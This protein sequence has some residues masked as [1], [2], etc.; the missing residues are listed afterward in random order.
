MVFLSSE[1]VCACFDYSYTTS[2]RMKM[3]LVPEV[4]VSNPMCAEKGLNKY[5]L[6]IQ[7]DLF[8]LT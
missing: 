8:V 4:Q 7:C 6:E 3:W 2:V 1:Q 5:V